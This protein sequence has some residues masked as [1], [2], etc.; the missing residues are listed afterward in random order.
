MFLQIVNYFSS[1]KYFHVKAERA[2]PRKGAAMKSQSC[3]KACPPSNRAGPMLRAGLTE[4]PVTGMQTMCTN[5]RVR[6]MA[7]PANE[8]LPN[9]F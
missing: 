8:A 4:V 6:P 3:D 9:F 7:K 5:T 1:A 2:A